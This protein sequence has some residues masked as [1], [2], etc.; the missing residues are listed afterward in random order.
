MQG[1]LNNERLDF[2]WQDQEGL[3]VR[4]GWGF[5][6]AI[7]GARTLV[8]F[9]GNGSDKEHKESILAELL[10]RSRQKPDPFSTPE[11]VLA[12]QDAMEIKY[13]GYDLVLQGRYDT[14]V[15][16]LEQ[17]L[18]AYS[19]HYRQQEQTSL[20]ADSD[21]TDV[22]NIISRLLQCYFELADYQ[23][24]PRRFDHP[25]TKSFYENSGT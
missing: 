15:P 18:V 6:R 3:D 10:T 22:I 8:G 21:L 16:L 19:T 13:A 20:I 5:L 1:S 12:T 17:A 2:I 4:M 23:N 25:A 11:T 7:L 9:W 24:V 14:A